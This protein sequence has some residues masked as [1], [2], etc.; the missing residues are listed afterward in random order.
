MLLEFVQILSHL[1]QKLFQLGLVQI[2]AMQDHF[3]V[4]RAITVEFGE[5]CPL[6]PVECP[7]AIGATELSR[8]IELINGIAP[9]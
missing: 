8:S 3:L 9:R 5:S 2:P 1:I 6:C 7:V 4:I